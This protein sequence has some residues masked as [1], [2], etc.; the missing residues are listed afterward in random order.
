V[1]ADFGG[2]PAPGWGK[3]PAAKRKIDVAPTTIQGLFWI[4]PT[5]LCQD[6][7]WLAPFW[8]KEKAYSLPD[9]CVLAQ[10]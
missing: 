2:W 7:E 10:M 5:C 3:H 8:Q 1:A 9:L 4:A 6:L